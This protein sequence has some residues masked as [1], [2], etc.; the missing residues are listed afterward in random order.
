MI[1]LGVNIDHVATIRQARRGHEPD[2]LKA[3]LLAEEFGADAITVHVRE[4]RRHM[5]DDDVRRIRPEIS[6]RLN[7]ECAVVDEMIRLVE[8]IKPHDVCFVPERREEVTTEGGLD[9]IGGFHLI[10]PAVA[11]L[12]NQGMRISLFIDPDLDQ[13]E[14]ALKCGADAIEL[15]T[16]SYAHATGASHHAELMRIRNAAN[17]GVAEGLRVNAGHGLNYDNVSPIAAIETISEL[18]I[19]H[20]IVANAVF[21]GWEAAI[22]KMKEL[23]VTARMEVIRPR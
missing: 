13:I 4:D 12:K 1:E 10:A 20:S 15:H 23:M 8:E 2:P 14:A 5:Q 22:K 16:G 17:F 7:F 19:G 3:A 21:M 18:N 9:V 11:R 6:T